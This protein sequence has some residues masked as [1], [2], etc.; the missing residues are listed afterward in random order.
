MK[1]IK[2]F[3][4]NWDSIPKSVRF[5]NVLLI[6]GLVVIGIF[7]W[8][9][10]AIL[11]ALGSVLTVALSLDDATKNH[12]WIAFMPITWFCVIGISI[13]VLLYKLYKITIVPFNNWINK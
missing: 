5:W 8:E 9:L 3:F 2:M 10:L 6:L 7:T 11:L 1:Y 13:C 4:H 12:L